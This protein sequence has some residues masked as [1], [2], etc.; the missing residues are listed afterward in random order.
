MKIF[1]NALSS[2][3]GLRTPASYAL[4]GTYDSS[5]HYPSYKK[6]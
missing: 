5:Y 4:A 1:A 3:E 2:Y 6:H